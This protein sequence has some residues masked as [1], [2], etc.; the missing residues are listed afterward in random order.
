MEKMI[1]KACLLPVIMTDDNE[2]SSEEAEG[3]LWAV[4]Y[5]MIDNLYTVWS[6]EEKF[7]IT[8]EQATNGWWYAGR[9]VSAAQAL[10]C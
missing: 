5:R 6:D 7:K 2:Q 10:N 3:L 8:E 1:I 4:C 9:K